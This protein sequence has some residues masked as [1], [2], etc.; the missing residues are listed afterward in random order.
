MADQIAYIRTLR[1][2]EPGREPYEITTTAFDSR[3]FEQHNGHFPAGPYKDKKGRELSTPSSDLHWIAWFSARRQ[4]QT[5]YTQY[6][7]WDVDDVIVEDVTDDEDDEIDFDEENTGQAE[8]DEFD[9]AG[10]FIDGA[11]PTRPGQSAD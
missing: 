5:E 10:P 6:A 3:R 8:R 1:I 4:K 7:R 9:E 2:T 11:D